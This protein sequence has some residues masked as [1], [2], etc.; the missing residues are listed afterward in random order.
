MVARPL[1]EDD[2]ARDQAGD[3]LEDYGGA[4]AR[5]GDDILFVIG[6]AFLAAGDQEP[7]FFVLHLLDSSGD[8]GAVDVDVEDVEED[9]EA[10]ESALGFDGDDFAIGRGDGDGTGWD[11]TL[12]VAEEIE[13]EERHKDQRDPEQWSGEP[14]DKSG[15]SAQRQGVVDSSRYDLQNTIFACAGGIA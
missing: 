14:G 4:V 12:G 7:P 11:L 6:G 15:G 2:T 3:L 13:A 5:D 1:G 8:R 9:T 10:F